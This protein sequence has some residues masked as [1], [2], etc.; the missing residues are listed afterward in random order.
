MPAAY[1]AKALG[2]YLVLGACTT[3]D[4]SPPGDA[5]PAGDARAAARDAAPDPPAKDG[6][7]LAPADPSVEA[8]LAGAIRL[9]DDGLPDKAL[10]VLQELD[11][12]AGPLAD[13]HLY[14]TA[15]CLLELK[16]PAAA[17]AALERLRE[18][19]GSRLRGEV[20]AMV[21]MS[22][23]LEDKFDAAAGEYADLVEKASDAD[24]RT[25]GL[26]L[27]LG[28]SYE[29]A[30]QT[31]NAK[32]AYGEIIRRFPF[33][34]EA[35]EA[36]EAF[37]RLAPSF[38]MPAAWT[39]QRVEAFE[40]KKMFGAALEELEKL[41]VPKKKDDKHAYLYR[42]ASLLFKA[43]GSGA[44]VLRILTR[45]IG[46]KSK[47]TDGAILLAA[48]CKSRMGDIKGARA[49]YQLYLKRYPG[50][51][52]KGEIVLTLLRYDMQEKRFVFILKT[53]A[54]FVT[55]PLFLG[56]EE[57][58][59]VRWIL[60][61]A[62]FLNGSHARAGAIFSGLKK[63][64]KDRMEL[65]RAD[66][67]TGV[68]LLEQGRKKQAAKVFRALFDKNPLH[69]YSILALMRLREMGETAVL[70]PAPRGKLPEASEDPC[71]LLPPSV[72]MLLRMKLPLLAKEELRHRKDEILKA[73]ATDPDRLLRIFACSGAQ[74]VLHDAL[75]SSYEKYTLFYPYE[76]IVSYWKILYPLFRMQDVES[77]SA[78]RGVSPWLTLSI[79]RQESRFDA[80]AVSYAGAM[81]LMQLMPKTARQVAATLGETYDPASM[82]DGAVNMRYGVTY[83]SSLVEKFN[84]NV[85][86][87]VAAYNGGPHN[88]GTW[89]GQHWTD[90][91][92]LFVELI[93]YDQTRTYVRRVM[94]SLIRYGYL[95]DG[96]VEPVVEMLGRKPEPKFK[97]SPDF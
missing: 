21:A 60:G 62:A 97:K 55:E 89:L 59:E 13:Y 63:G 91:P 93:P 71:A 1:P 53:Y 56:P 19:K 57:H 29:N 6:E 10:P 79:I 17:R 11:G 72:Q 87:A 96:S 68:T 64:T 78:E 76:D 77:L 25:P 84:G 42:K 54:R 86:L 82:L 45:L 12:K 80:D 3:T 28:R 18:M 31:V 51:A 46:Q 8:R 49:L 20:P 61:F 33:S 92:D 73:Y 74:E 69:Y 15:R 81:G 34:R 70:P 9:V 40:K 27:M 44:E 50:S 16:R 47:N 58:R 83:L 7:P 66:Y 35:P 37:T 4:T 94:T 95:Y 22:H 48:R 5:G 41:P 32:G 30:Q 38:A 2:F 75:A 90:R 88:V 43:R 65:M 23:F 26:I 14:Y 39:A 67:W 52:S 85:P 36:L 24:D